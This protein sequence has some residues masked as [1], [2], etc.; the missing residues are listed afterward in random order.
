MERDETI[1][2]SGRIIAEFD[3][4][5]SQLLTDASEILTEPHPPLAASECPPPAT[6]QAKQS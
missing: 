1:L 3:D 4:D 6:P 2:I 5:A